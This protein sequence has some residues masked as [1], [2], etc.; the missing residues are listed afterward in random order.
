MTK[1]N[2]NM[3]NGIKHSRASPTAMTY[4]FEPH[5]QDSTQRGKPLRIAT[6]SVDNAVA[7]LKELLYGLPK[8]SR[9]NDRKYP[10]HAFG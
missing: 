8:V 10:Q 4:K 2:I 7:T 6:H 1:R 3:N 5:Y 9:L